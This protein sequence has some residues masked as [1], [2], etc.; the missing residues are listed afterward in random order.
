MSAI[1]QRIHRR[2]TRG[3]RLPENTMC[4]GRPS[5]WGNPFTPLARS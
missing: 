1:P 2:R 4:V 5:V 3:W